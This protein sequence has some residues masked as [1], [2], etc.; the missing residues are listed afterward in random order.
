LRRIRLDTYIGMFFSN[1]VA[2]FIVITTAAT[3]HAHGVTD[4]QTSSQAALALKPIAG[5]FVFVIFAL[6]IVGTG[7]LAVPVLAGSAAYAVGE[8]FGWHVGLARKLKRARAFYGV[9]SR[10]PWW[11]ARSSISSI[12]TRSRPCSGAR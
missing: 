2:L 3:L 12:S 5:P 1:A 11:W 8:T 9:R 6:G 7:L 4:I 10:W